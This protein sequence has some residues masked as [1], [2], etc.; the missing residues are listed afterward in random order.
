MLELRADRFYWAATSMQHSR[1]YLEALKQRGQ[2]KSYKQR[3]ANFPPA[4]K[5]FYARMIVLKES[6]E[7]L[8]AKFSLLPCYK[9]LNSLKARDETTLEE[10][11]EIL[12]EIDSRLKDELSLIKIYVIDHKYTQ[13]LNDSPLFGSEVFSAFPSANEDI[14]ES[15][16][17]LSMGRATACVMHLMRVCEAGLV[18]LATALGVTRQNDW[19]SYLREIDKQ[20]M[21]N[22]RGASTKRPDELFYAEAA[23]SFDHVRRSWR[24]PTLHIERSYSVERAEEIFQA[25]RS[26]MRHLATLIHE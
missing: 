23:S 11:V 1:S 3:I 12:S 7:T 14:A 4:H 25:V 13:F 19:G 17:C 6:L 26:F 16:A 18:A 5:E 2:S 22:A 24:N 8:G 21:A 15:G 9:L 20:L 10:V